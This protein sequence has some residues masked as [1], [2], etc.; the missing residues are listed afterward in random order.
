MQYVHVRLNFIRQ[1]NTW[2]ENFAV[3]Q[4]EWED[5][6][7]RAMFLASHE[8]RAR[9]GNFDLKDYDVLETYTN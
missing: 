8:Q 1:L 2:S 3:K 5:E 7:S 6:I 9:N 4:S